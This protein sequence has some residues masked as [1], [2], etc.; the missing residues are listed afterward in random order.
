MAM[1]A[2]AGLHSTGRTARIVGF[3]SPSLCRVAVAELARGL[4]H[5]AVVVAFTTARAVRNKDGNRRA[6]AVASTT[7]SCRVRCLMVCLVWGVNICFI[8]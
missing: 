3:V 8:R 5:S 2:V 6:T 1:L 7:L 4:W